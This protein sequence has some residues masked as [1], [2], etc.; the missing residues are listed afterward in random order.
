MTEEG[1]HLLGTIIERF[2]V[3][4]KECQG[5]SIQHRLLL[6]CFCLFP[7]F[8]HL[9][10]G[11]QCALSDNLNLPRADDV[12][13]ALG[14]KQQL[15]KRAFERVHEQ[16]WA[17]V[18]AAVTPKHKVRLVEGAQPFANSWVWAIPGTHIQA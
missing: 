10:I 14:Y 4:T 8:N 9:I 18:Y 2:L 15:Q 6:F 5:L 17:E 16:K 13:D 12:L 7:T 1:A 11:C 3:R